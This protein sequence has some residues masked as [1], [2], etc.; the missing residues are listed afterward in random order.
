[1]SQNKNSTRYYSNLHEESVCRALNAK[2]TLNS[3][4][5]KFRKGD[6][7][8]P[9]LLLVECK[10]STSEKKSVS[11]KKEWIDKNQ[12]ETKSMRLDNGCICFNFGPNT[13]NYYVISEKLMKYLVENLREE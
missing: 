13:D 8:I 2:R 3:G 10:T 1:M 7:Y 5:T 12:E 4:A 11:I 9:E 6:C